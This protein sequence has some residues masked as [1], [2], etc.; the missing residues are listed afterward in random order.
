MA[1]K[2]TS[3]LILFF[4]LVLI[5][6]DAAQQ[7]YYIDAFGLSEEPISLT[8]L[9]K[10]QFVRWLVWLVFAIP[11]GWVS[12][13]KL[14]ADE[15][16]KSTD[17]VKL[18]ALVLLCIALSIPIISLISIW[19][20]ELALS[21]AIFQ[22]FMLFFAFQKGLT[23]FMAYSALILLL[24]NQA[25]HFKMGIQ[26]KEISS[27]RDTS[28]RLSRTIE[29]LDGGREPSISIKTGS[30]LTPIPIGKI[31]WIQADDYCV[32]LHTQDRTHTLRKSMRKLEDELKNFG[33]LRIHRAALINLK[34]LDQ[35]NFDSSTIHLKDASELPL[36]K[37]G[38][39]V[40]KKR[41]HKLS[42]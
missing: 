14:T 21:K 30:R 7:K 18:F 4:L 20:Q 33:F 37:S 22:E 11:L 2:G 15:K 6:F 23:F 12:W 10:T 13:R 26:E 42:L 24:K 8:F 35:V 36:S 3:L 41:M 28:A 17:R 39:R 19:S 31:I 34:F 27:L 5:V 1:I 29:D 25:D 40:L 32:R 16:L 9:L 38:A